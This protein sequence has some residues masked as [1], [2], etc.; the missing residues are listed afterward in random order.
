MILVVDDYLDVAATVC[1]VLTAHGYP[2]LWAKEGGEA[3]AIIKGYPEGSPLLVI[4]DQMMP[5]ISGI[6]VL[7]H[8][9]ND[10]STADTPA[11]MLSAGLHIRHRIEAMR[12]KVLQWLVK[13]DDLS[14][15]AQTIG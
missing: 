11:I 3:L 13:G 9:R 10:P 14:T 4:L 12:L 8:L 1:K 6:E 2:C 7:R 15:L 5:D